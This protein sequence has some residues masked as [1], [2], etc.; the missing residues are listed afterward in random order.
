MIDDK[1]RSKRKLKC[2]RHKFVASER[3]LAETGCGDVVGVDLNA[4]EIG[5]VS[6]LERNHEIQNG[7]EQFVAV[8][9]T[10]E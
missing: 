8:L 5:A 2:K 7:I 1:G 9:Q 6:L 4:L 3:G 10:S